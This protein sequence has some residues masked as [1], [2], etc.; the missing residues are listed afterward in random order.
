MLLAPDDI[1]PENSLL[2]AHADSAAARPE[3]V[4]VTSL[5]NN[6][7]DPLAPFFANPA[8]IETSLVVGLVCDKFA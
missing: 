4:A 2:F 1:A 7:V 5:E 6:V 3:G 8:V